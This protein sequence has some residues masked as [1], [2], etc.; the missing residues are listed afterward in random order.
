MSTATA[1]AG[2]APSTELTLAA[3][4]TRAM[5]FL[6]LCG[7][8]ALQW[9]QM[10]EPAA[11]QRAGYAVLAAAFAIAGLLLAGRLPGRAR[12]PAA[13]LVALAAFALALLAGGVADEMLLPAN[14]GELAAQVGRGLST[15]PG[16]RVP[17]R[18][19]DESTRLVIALG[20][21]VLSV[22]A[23]LVAFWPRRGELGLRHVALVLLM[24]LYAV[25]AVALDLSSEF[26]SGALLAL[27]VVAY[28]RLERLQITDAGLAGFLAISVTILALAAA[29]LL[30]TGQPW[31]DYETWALSN[32]T[33]KSTSY[34]WDHSY[35]PLDWP[36]DGRELLRV[37]AKRPAYWKASNLDDFDG[38]IW[39]RDRTS[40]NQDGCGDASA[41]LNDDTDQYLQRIRVTVRNLRT[42][43]YV[44]AG[45]A[46]AV[47]PRGLGWLP[48]GDGTYASSSR[49]LRR[50][51][52]YTALVYTPNPNGRDRRVAPRIYPATMQRY[53]AIELSR[54]MEPAP[55][56]SAGARSLG[57][58]IQ[59]PMYGEP[60][61]PMMT[62][63]FDSHAQ[64]TPARR[65]L[66]DSRYAR[67][68]ALARRLSRAA[69]TQE[70]FVQSVI[71]YLG[72]DDFSYTE[73]P[74]RSAENLDGFLFDSKSGYCQM[75]SGAMALL[76][77]MGGVPA[78]VSVGF[79][80]GLLDRR[81][82]EYVVRDFDAH[83][84]VE[85]WYAGFGWVQMDPTPSDAPAR[86]QTDDEAAGG[87]L[88][89]RGAPD[90]GGDIRSDPGRGLATID[91]GVPW[92]WIATGAVLLIAGAALAFWLLR[93]RRRMLAAG[94][95]P[96][97]ELERALER[98][99]RAPG[100]AATLSTIEGLFARTPAAAGYVRA[101]REQRYSGR[102]A[103]ATPSGRRAVRAELARGA[104]PLGRL[105][106]WWALPPKPR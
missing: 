55:D 44:T 10:L 57:Y 36:R 81:T 87:S 21:T 42:Q 83:S 53:T 97:A 3:P 38:S 64:P 63:S 56:P 9:M 5:T 76:L 71:R 18:G 31:F 72:Q 28:L 84:W 43:T 37:K 33:S 92:A 23:A 85:V 65:F 46:C 68:Y 106:A 51:D 73:S 104:G 22:V 34:S 61:Q 66:A 29:P 35:G 50:G 47:F 45:V 101:L 62:P 32:A 39:K 58:R 96:V 75:Y 41:Y 1:R 52:A 8:A 59:F 103:Q 26:L 20:G 98:A 82:G 17:Y 16:A 11:R 77:R 49:E 93:R 91:Q 13:I 99:R 102:E 105:R 60:G 4:I 69:P 12:T 67:T 80:T 48:L 100:P 19:L 94:W 79:T 95:G 70:D 88:T 78:R 89:S 7:F 14:W 86:S 6:A 25:P 40:T 2:P 30:D 90:L 27:L 15:L 74:P 54:P 24:V